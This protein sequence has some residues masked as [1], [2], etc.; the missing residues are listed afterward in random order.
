MLCEVVARDLTCIFCTHGLLFKQ[1]L[2]HIAA[3]GSMMDGATPSYPG[4][5][6]EKRILQLIQ[7]DD[8]GQVHGVHADLDCIQPEGVYAAAACPGLDFRWRLPRDN[9]GSCAC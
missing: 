7:I 6:H 2:M 3:A 9:F 8:Q 5:M 4:V 1:A